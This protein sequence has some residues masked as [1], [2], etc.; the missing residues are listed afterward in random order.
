[1]SDDYEKWLRD[2]GAE[3]TDANG[4][5]AAVALIPWWARAFIAGA[6]IKGVKYP[7][8]TVA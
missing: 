7:L 6:A 8:A 2:H 5:D 4:D 1:M 3:P